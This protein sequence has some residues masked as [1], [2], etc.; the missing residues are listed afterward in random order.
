MQLNLESRTWFT[1]TRYPDGQQSLKLNNL[2]QTTF[3]KI[4][5]M[6]RLRNWSDLELLILATKTLRQVVHGNVPISLD[7]PYFIG[8]RS[9]RIFEERTCHYL[10]DVICP[11]INAQGYS[12]VTLLDP[13][14]DVLPGLLNNSVMQPLSYMQ[15]WLSDIPNC[16]VL[17][18]DAGAEKRYSKVLNRDYIQAVKC[19]DVTTGKITGTR[20][21]G[22][23][24]KL[25]LVIVDD[26]CDGG[27]T[28]IELA[29]VAK[30]Q[31]CGKIYLAITHG[32]FSSGFS[33]LRQY[34]EKIY[35]TNSFSDIA[36]DDFVLQTVVV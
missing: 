32:I 33:Q 25:D 22:D 11:I 29:K 1:A 26:L 36:E 20:I 5:L 18:P 12:R 17:Y 2:P 16:V 14:S 19:R 31:G 21:L 8:A 23:V 13:H 7:V 28:F 35:C 4:E 6:S 30:E 10:R 34:F 27:R 9:D 15:D 3:E 24:N